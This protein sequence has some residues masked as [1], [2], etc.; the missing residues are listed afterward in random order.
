MSAD[1]VTLLINGMRYGGFT[2]IDFERGIDR[3]ASTFNVAVSERWGTRK[4]PWRVNPFDAVKVYIAGDLALTGYIES[5]IPAFS[6]KTHGVRIAGHSLTKQLVDCTPDIPSGQFNGYS[7]AAIARSVAA[8]F[9]IETVVETPLADM[10]IPNANLERCETAFS[11]LE[12]LCRLAGVMMTDNPAGN[13]VL[14]TAGVTRAA[15]ALVQGEN[16]LEAHGTYNVGRRFSDYI[17]LGQ[18]GINHGSPSLK[19]LGG[20]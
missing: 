18:A 2:E 17:L 5:Y 9:G 20:K 10:V 16:I 6:A 15:S 8:I 4:Q 13:L 19:G 14:T 7:V 12:R 3:V 11:F 1:P